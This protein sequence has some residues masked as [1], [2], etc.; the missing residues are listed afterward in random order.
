M[1][2]SQIWASNLLSVIKY[3][4]KYKKMTRAPHMPLNIKYRDWNYIRGFLKA[5]AIPDP[6]GQPLNS[7]VLLMPRKVILKQCSDYDS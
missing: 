3:L 1:I 5:F 2:N 4:H 7:F 6:L